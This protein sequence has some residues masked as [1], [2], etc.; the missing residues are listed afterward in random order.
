MATTHWSFSSGFVPRSEWAS[1]F[2]RWRLPGLCESVAGAW[3]WNG[4]DPHGGEPWCDVGT[5]SR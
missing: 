3:N 4:P 2:S 1:G 5:G